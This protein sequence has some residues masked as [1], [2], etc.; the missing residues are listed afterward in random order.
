V[1]PPIQDA[2]NRAS[3]LFSSVDQPGHA[4]QM[5]PGAIIF[6]TDGQPTVGETNEDK[7]V[8]SIRQPL[9]NVRIFSF[10]DRTDIN[11]HLLDRIG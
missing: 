10:G 4:S 8:A 5:R 11:T 7:L 9:T 6:L 3:Q 1:A 2:L